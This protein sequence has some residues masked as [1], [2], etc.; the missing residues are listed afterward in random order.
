MQDTS[1]RAGERSPPPTNPCTLATPSGLEASPLAAKLQP[2]E[3]LEGRGQGGKEPA[4]PAKPGAADA[5]RPGPARRMG[6]APA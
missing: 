4:P 2:S 6:A 1:C 5:Q 3:G